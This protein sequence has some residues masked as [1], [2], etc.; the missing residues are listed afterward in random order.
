LFVKCDGALRQVEEDRELALDQP[1][2][3]LLLLAEAQAR[4]RRAEG[5][6]VLEARRLEQPQ[7]S[8][9]APAAGTET[10]SEAGEISHQGR[11]W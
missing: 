11:E 3:A 9:H 8:A 7:L 1:V 4:D 2:N 5:V 10:S 6:A